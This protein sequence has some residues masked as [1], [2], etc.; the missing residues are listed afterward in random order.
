MP[1]LVTAVEFLHGL[2]GKLSE[3]S[4]MEL[5]V[6]FVGN[7]TLTELSRKSNWFKTLYSVVSKRLT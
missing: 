5:I 2:T 6:L 4:N 3:F 1:D 7:G